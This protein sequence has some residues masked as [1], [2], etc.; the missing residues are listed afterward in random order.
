MCRVGLVSEGSFGG[1]VC[2]AFYFDLMCGVF[3]AGSERGGVRW[4]GRGRGRH[5]EIIFTFFSRDRVRGSIERDRGGREMIANGTF[6]G[7]FFLKT[8]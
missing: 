8:S 3:G 7:S 6:Y 5:R 1:C 2:G 4:R